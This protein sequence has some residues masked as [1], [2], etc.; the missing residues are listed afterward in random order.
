MK[1]EVEMLLAKIFSTPD[2]KIGDPL[3]IEFCQQRGERGNNFITREELLAYVE[4]NL[5]K[6]EQCPP[7]FFLAIARHD[8]YSPS[9]A[10]KEKLK[11]LAMEGNTGLLA[12]CAL[13]EIHGKQPLIFSELY[14]VSLAEGLYQIEKKTS[15]ALQYACMFLDGVRLED[16]L[17]TF[18]NLSER[19]Y[20]PAQLSLAW[21]HELGESLE[22][23]KEE[24]VILY[25]KAATQ[26]YAL[27]QCNVGR[28][29]QY[30]R[31]VPQNIEK[32]VKFY[33]QSAAQG[34]AN[35]QRKLGCMYLN[36]EGVPQS[37]AEAFK[38]YQQ[39]VAQGYALAQC[40][41]GWM[42]L[43]GRGVPQSDAEAVKLY[44]QSAA[45]GN[46]GAQN[47]LGVMYQHGQGVP[48][49]DAEA[50]KLYQ[51][52]AAQGNALAQ[53][54]LGRMYLEGQGV[55]QS[56]AEAVNLYEQSAAQGNALAQFNL[57]WMYRKGLRGLPQDLERSS[58]YCA[59]AYFKKGSQVNEKQKKK[60]L[61]EMLVSNYIESGILAPECEITGLALL[62][63]IKEQYPNSPLAKLILISKE[64]YSRNTLLQNIFVKTTFAGGTAL[65]HL[66]D[67]GFTVK[68]FLDRYSFAALNAISFGIHASTPDRVLE[69][70]KPFGSYMVYPGVKIDVLAEKL[71]P[72]RFE[73]VLGISPSIQRAI[74]FYRFSNVNEFE[75]EIQTAQAVLASASPSLPQ[76]IIDL[77]LQQIHPELASCFSSGF[78]TKQV[79]QTRNGRLV[80]FEKQGIAQDQRLEVQRKQLAEQSKK[81]EAL[82]TRLKSLEPKS[83]CELPKGQLTLC[84]FFK[85]APSPSAQGKESS[86]KKRLHSATNAKN[87]EEQVPLK[88]RKREEE[89]LM[90]RR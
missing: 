63:K 43:K 55:P 51:Q 42:Y 47:S 72:I 30:G 21:E 54:N 70:I 9:E 87:S 57:A 10:L 80:A 20:P 18:F 40:N 49:S 59:L 82:E 2:E 44:Q 22:A 17:S 23:N 90:R 14:K 35:A 8:F 25:K 6:L 3:V 29:Y 36:G 19:G 5:D 76:E 67:P 26:G 56:D 74:K 71:G 88:K 31:G 48:Q 28:M 75:A 68:G 60:F 11:A 65:L 15:I 79:E 69:E 27:A 1:E 50:I 16:R 53:C 32:A 83:E 38:L 52:S 61:F 66:L 78:W 24:A 89:K 37:D 12:L 81:I 34:Y 86:S 62:K 73:K 39:S 41:L 85:V 7:L 64:D 45:Q 13:V 58:H 77:I 4:S 46:S 84:K 33:Q